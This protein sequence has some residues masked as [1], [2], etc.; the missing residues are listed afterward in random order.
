VQG[1]TRYRITLAGK[2]AREMGYVIVVTVMSILFSL[3]SVYAHLSE[4]IYH[5]F[6][7]CYSSEAFEYLTNFVFLYL[8]GILGLTHRKWRKSHN[9]EQELEVIISSISPDAMLVIDKE[10]TITM[11]NPSVQRVFGYTVG[12][13][14][15][16][17]TEFLYH[18]R[19]SDKFRYHEIYN[20]LEQEGFHIGH[21]SG[22]RKDGKEI[23][24]EI[25][26]GQLSNREGAVLLLRDTSDKEAAEAER[27]ESGKK[28][29]RIF[30]N[31]VEGIFQSTPE[32]R[33][34]SLNPAMAALHGYASAEEMIETVT[35]ISRN[36]YV[37]AGEITVFMKQLEERG[38]I[39]N[40]EH[41]SYRKD[42]TTI[43]VSVSARAVKDP[44]GK[45]LFYEGTHMDITSRK[46][47][48]KSLRESMR[49]LTGATNAIIAV[50]VTAVEA[51][52]PY[53][54]GHQK[55]VANLARAIAVEMDLSGPQIQ[56]IVMA[57]MIHDLG[58]ISVP[59]EILSTPKV[60]S[61]MEFELVRQHPR[62]G[63]DILKDIRFEWPIAEM[64]LQHHERLD[65]SG[66]PQ[67]L[68]GSKILFEARILAV[69][70]VVEAISNHRPYRPAHG[71]DVA[72]EE[73]RKNTGRLYDNDVVKAC[74]RV[75]AEGSFRFEETE[76]P[77][78][79]KKT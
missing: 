35:D 37:N 2:K 52:D 79:P 55:R 50:I 69:A 18:D 46:A 23:T 13:V 72:L 67:G 63:Y 40:F 6:L 64:V 42:G 43:W 32:G 58:K 73:I 30:E 24:L 74:M 15:D 1:I 19:R 75:F 39:E 9:R 49:R 76:S 36:L 12:E 54:A 62:T 4:R 5:H 22:R 41:E 38:H 20:I 3:L 34:L 68:A 53:T 11:C 25:I 51:R 8:I 57:G 70:D 7:S 26:T 33:F 17:K 48:E 71:I 47:S 77:Y 21:A 61:S 59:A 44:E 14:L 31:A 78:D 66:Y 45:V 27:R 10:R 16:Q 29:R 28:Y 65:G 56:G 60:L